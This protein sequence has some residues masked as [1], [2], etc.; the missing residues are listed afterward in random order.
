M[1]AIKD[2][3]WKVSIITAGMKFRWKAV[4]SDNVDHPTRIQPRRSRRVKSA[5][6]NWERFAKLNKIP[7]KNWAYV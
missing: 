3:K 7:E 4:T 2:A 5:Q 6:D 1:I